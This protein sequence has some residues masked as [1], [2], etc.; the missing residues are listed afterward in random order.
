[1]PWSAGIFIRTDGTRTGSAVWTAAANAGVDIEEVDHDVHDQDIADGLEECLKRTGGNKMTAA[2]EMDGN[3]L[4][5][6]GG[7]VSD[8][9]R[10]NLFRVGSGVVAKSTVSEGDPTW[11]SFS[12]EAAP[13]DGV[14][15][16]SF[17]WLGNNSVPVQTVFGEVQARRV[18][19]LSGSEAGSVDLLAQKAGAKTTI[20]SA[21]STG[22]RDEAG[23][24]VQGLASAAAAPVTISGMAE[25]DFTGIRSDASRI[26]ITCI[27]LN[28]TGGATN[29][30]LEVL[31]GNSGGFVT[32]GYSTR[33]SMVTASAVA[34]LIAASAVQW[35]VAQ[36]LAEASDVSG[37]IVLERHGNG[38]IWTLRGSLMDAPDAAAGHDSTGEVSAGGTLDRVKIRISANSFDSGTIAVKAE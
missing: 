5:A 20:L 32:S 14:S 33:T 25:L 18:T 29:E 3:E 12:D 13:G 10:L 15:I 34:T 4:L 19:G 1:M 36:G 24:L 9:F 22:I 27:D 21:G 26:T 8:V 35:Q 30:Q 16:G 37:T 11:Q 17:Q 6:G 2:L 23:N 28:P 38:N 31:V 7:A